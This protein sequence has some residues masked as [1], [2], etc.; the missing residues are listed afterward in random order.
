MTAKEYL[1]QAFYLNQRIESSLKEVSEM[2]Y[3]ASRIESP[4][5]EEH[6]NPNHATEAPFIKTLEK[7]WALE[8]QIDDEVDRL[9]D[10][11]AEIRG[12]INEVPDQ[13]QQMLLRHR[14]IH[15]RSWEEI[16]YEMDIRHRWVHTLHARALRSVESILDRK[17]IPYDKNPRKK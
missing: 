7:V 6:H 9:V 1:K 4:G 15:F 5:F 12:V 2:K 16:E 10:L 14:Y 3:M 13:K 11:K 17:G 8:Q